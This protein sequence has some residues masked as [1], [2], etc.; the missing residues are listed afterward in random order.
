MSITPTNRKA[1]HS[2]NRASVLALT[3]V[4]FSPTD[5]TAQGLPVQ[6]GPMLP[7]AIWWVGAFLLALAL[8][9]GIMRNRTRTRAEKELTERATKDLQAQ[10]ARDEKRGYTQRD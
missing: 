4:V 8:V 9:Y 1:G 3:G 6:N 2:L 10:D 5:L 7:V